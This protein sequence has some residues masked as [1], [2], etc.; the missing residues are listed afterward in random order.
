VLVRGPLCCYNKQAELSCW[1]REIDRVLQVKMQNPWELQDR[2][3][4]ANDRINESTLGHINE[5]GLSEW[6][7]HTNTTR[8]GYC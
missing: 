8:K 6:E 4:R 7:S 1:D 3:V 5:R 2:P